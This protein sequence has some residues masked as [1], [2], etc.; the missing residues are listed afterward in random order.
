[1]VKEIEYNF[2]H[3]SGRRLTSKWKDEKKMTKELIEKRGGKY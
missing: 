1:M 2:E 3:I